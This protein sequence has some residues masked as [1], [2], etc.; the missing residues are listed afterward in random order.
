MT[1]PHA[2]MKLAYVAGPYRGRTHH[3]VSQNIAAAREVAAHLWS[4]GYAVIC[5]HLNSAFMSGAAPEE[6]FLNGGLAMLRRCDLVVL[7]PNWQASQG[8]A[9]EIEEARSCGLP[10]FS[11]IEFVPPAN[12]TEQCANE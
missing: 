3:D 10:V 7:V 2:P 12:A 9:R 8:T 4:L 5:P 1:M 11:D 6:T